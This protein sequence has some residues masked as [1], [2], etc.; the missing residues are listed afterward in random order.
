[1][2][3]KDI[4]VFN[5]TNIF[6]RKEIY[7]ISIKIGVVHKSNMYVAR[8]VARVLCAQFENFYW[9]NKKN[10]CANMSV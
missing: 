5:L 2:Y 8:V 7:L 9:I 10:V 4:N 6:Y 3:L 1:M